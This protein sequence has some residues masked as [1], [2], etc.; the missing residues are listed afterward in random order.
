M[1]F[2][3]LVEICLWPHLAVKGL[4]TNLA[5]KKNIYKSHKPVSKTHR[6]ENGIFDSLMTFCFAF[7]YFILGMRSDRKRPGFHFR[8]KKCSKFYGLNL[9]IVA[10]IFGQNGES[11]AFTT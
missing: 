4:R 2:G 1:K 5:R 6:P 11:N 9:S 8:G 3:N 10:L 7:S